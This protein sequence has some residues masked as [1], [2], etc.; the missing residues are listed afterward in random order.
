MRPNRGRGRTTMKRREALKILAGA[1]AAPSLIPSRGLA[2]NEQT[3]VYHLKN[4]TNPFYKNVRDGAE[5]AAKDLGVNIHIAAPTKPDNIEEQIR[6]V[7]DWI[8]KK[9]DG[10]V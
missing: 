2:A 3:I 8:V 10:M 9:P 6:L 1:V 4:V 5:R 7:E